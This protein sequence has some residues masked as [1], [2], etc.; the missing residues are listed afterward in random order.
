MWEFAVRVELG[1]GDGAGGG[2]GGGVRGFFLRL[3]FYCG[4]YI[5]K[6]RSERP[7]C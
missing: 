2:E 4:V 6:K 7:I 5:W 3:I 1:L